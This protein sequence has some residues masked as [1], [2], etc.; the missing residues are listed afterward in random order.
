LTPHDALTAAAAEGPDEQAVAGSWLDAARV[1]TDRVRGGV[2]APF[3]QGR[4]MPDAGMVLSV[5]G[6]WVEQLNAKVRPTVLGVLRGAY[7][8]VRGQQPPPGFDQ[9]AYVT[10]YLD[11]SVNRMVGIPDEVYRQISRVIADGVAAGDPIPDIAR[12]VDEV[13]T[14]TGSERWAN[15]SVVVARTE[16]GGAVNAG[17]LAAAGARQLETRTPMVKT[18]VATTHGPSAERTRPAHLLADGQTVNLTEAFI[19]GGE[20][21]QFPGDPSGS[22]GNVIQCR[23]TISTRAA[24]ER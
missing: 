14:V 7:A 3:R 24:E 18:W 10:Q 13:L 16:V 5:N 12:Q 4:T 19:V 22:A 23:C 17:T 8:R 9:A 1:W 21:L 11:A 20:P 6:V 2:M 15:R